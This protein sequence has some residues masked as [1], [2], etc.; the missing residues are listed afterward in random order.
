MSSTVVFRAPC[1]ALSGRALSVRAARI[2]RRCSPARRSSSEPSKDC[3][4]SAELLKILVCPLSKEP[5][6]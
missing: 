2:P 3:P 4:V 6:R 5:L 1:R